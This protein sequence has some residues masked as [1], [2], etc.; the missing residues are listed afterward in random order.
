M[1]PEKEIQNLQS[2]I[3]ELDK[4]KKQTVSRVSD[5]VLPSDIR[6]MVE[7]VEIPESLLQKKEP[8]ESQSLLDKGE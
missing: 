5:Q 7:E 4:L 6:E 8:Q 2:G 1:S 3:N